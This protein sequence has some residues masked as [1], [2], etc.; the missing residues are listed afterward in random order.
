MAFKTPITMS[1]VG[2]LSLYTLD[3]AIPRTMPSG[4]VTEKKKTIIDFIF[5]LYSAWKTSEK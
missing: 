2:L 3:M 5:L 4:V 1:A